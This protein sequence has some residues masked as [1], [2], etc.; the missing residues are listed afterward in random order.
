M[1]EKDPYN[2]KAHREGYASRAVYKLVEMDRLFS[3]FDGKTRILDLGASPGSWSQYAFEVTGAL[4][5]AIDISPI[6]LDGIKFIEGDIKD[7]SLVARIKKEF[8]FFDLIMSD[9]APKMSGISAIDQ[10]KAIELSRSSVPFVDS[11]LSS[12]GD[13]VVKCFQGDGFKEF[14]D[15]IRQRFRKCKCFVPKA[16]RRHSPEVYVVCKGFIA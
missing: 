9:A 6:R 10:A 3:L 8:G 15:S 16:S 12:D 5:A 4:V 2:E 1:R 13:F 7:A 14:Y 11:V